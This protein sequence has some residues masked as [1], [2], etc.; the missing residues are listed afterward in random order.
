IVERVIGTAMEAIHELPGTT[1][2][3]P[4]QRGEYDSEKMAALTLTE[5]EQW[6]ALAVASY[7][8]TVHSSLGQT[9]AGR[10]AQDV[11]V[12]GGPMVMA[13]PTGLWDDFLPVFRRQLVRT[14]FVSHHVWYFADVLKPLTAV[15][16]HLDRITM[17]RDPPDIRRMWV[18]KPDG[19]EYIEVPYR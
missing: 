14:G 16:E 1:F 2:S 11:A 10:W 17:R 15:R 8:G 5:L 3:N 4:T 12:A 19:V 7:H 6:L 13:N 18:L 9:P